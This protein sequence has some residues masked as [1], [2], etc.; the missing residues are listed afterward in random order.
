MGGVVR[1]RWDDTSTERG[2]WWKFSVVMVGRLDRVPPSRLASD[3]TCRND[4]QDPSSGQLRDYGL[5]GYA[6]LDVRGGINLTR[7][8]A[9]TLAVENLTD[10]KY[11]PA[12]SRWD[13]PGINVL[14]SL[15]LR[16]R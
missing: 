7:Y 3:P 4:P 6:V 14:L 8:A 16:V 1:V 5:P 13:A 9:V 11:R 12:H 10:K 15:E 2:L